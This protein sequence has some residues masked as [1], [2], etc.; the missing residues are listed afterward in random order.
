M[1][2]NKS[3]LNFVFGLFFVLSSCAPAVIGG[4]AVGGYKGATDKRTVGTMMD[5][6]VISTKV[7]TKLIADE[8]VKA[9]HIDVDV[10]DGVVYLL[11][12]VETESEKTM[13]ASIARGVEHVKGVRNQIMVG[14][15]TVGQG[16][17]DMYLASKIKTYLIKEPNIQSTNVDVD[18]FNNVVTL[19]GSAR[20]AEE[21]E[22]IIAIAKDVSKNAKIVDNIII[23]N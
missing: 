23:A 7:K 14:S 5:D 18:V 8:F 13:A 9:R 21:K 16:F 4:A 3:I 15:K 17:E 6:S 12:V 20:T 19:K 2:F 10:L 22:R 1:K 11:G